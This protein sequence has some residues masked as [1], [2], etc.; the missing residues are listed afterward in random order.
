MNHLPQSPLAKIIHWALLSGTVATAPA[1]WAADAD[2]TDEESVERIE[3]TGSRIKRTDMETPS[4]V[5]SINREDIDRSGLT[6]LSDVLK[7]ITTN[8][9]SL[10]LQTNNGNT[11]GVS[12]I[13]LRN[14]GSNRTLVL[15]NGRR[16]VANLGG[17]VDIST[18]PLAAVARLEVL[19]D[20]ASSVYGTDAICG[21]VNVITRND[22]DGA[23][24]SAYRGITS[25]DDGERQSYALTI[26]SAGE[27]GSA[28]INASYTKQEG[29]LGGDRKISSTPID[30]LPA[31]ISA[32]GGRAS[33]VTP[34]GQFGVALDPSRPTV[35]TP[36]TLDPSAQ[37]CL[38][39]QRCTST[40][41]F[42]PYNSNSDGYNFAPVNYIN[43]PSETTSLFVQGGYDLRDNVRATT[44]ILFNERSSKAQLAAQ[45]LSGSAMRVSK[46]NV[47]NPFGAD[48]TGATFRPI[49]APREYSVD[50]DTW[51]F[52][53]GLEGDFELGSRSFS[54][55]VGSTYSDNELVQI[56]SG[57][58]NAAN[59]TMALGPSTIRDGR[60]VCT[61]ANA[62]SNCVPF[63]LFGGPTGVTPEM[64]NFVTVTPRNVDYQKMHDYSANLTGDLFDLPAGPLAM[65]VGMETRRESGYSKPD[66]LT[67]AG[68]VLGD[69]PAL[70]TEGGFDLKEAYVEFNVPVLNDLPGVD[71]LELSLATRHS[72]YS[73]FGTTDNPRFAL[74]Y[75]PFSDL[76]FRASKGE[77]FRA[78]SI[79]ELFQGQS[80]GR[81]AVTDPCS[82]NST[83]YLSNADVR[84]RCAAEGVS[85]SFVQLSPQAFST[86]GGNPDVQPEMAT[87][88]TMGFVYSPSFVE[89]LGVTL[90]WY[91]IKIENSIS[92]RG[93]QSI[94]DD[95]Y[96]SG[97]AGRCA[98]ITR[99]L[100]GVGTPNKGELS[101]IMDITSNFRGGQEV[102]GYDLNVDYRFETAVGTWRVNWDNAYTTYFGDV[103]QLHRGELNADGDLSD[104]NLVGLVTAGS[105]AGGTHF[106]LK[107]NITVA[108]SMDDWSASITAQYFSRQTERCNNITTA[109][110]GL[111]RPEL[112]A[113]CSNP[114]GK[115]IKYT[116]NNATGVIK[117]SEEAWPTN[118]L[119]AT[120]Y[121]DAQ[122]GWKTPWDSQVTVGIRNLTDEDPPH[123]YSAFA[124]T[125][126]P[127]YRVPGQFYY[128]SYTQN[129]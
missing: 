77:G 8:G 38:P 56:K 26:G 2:A 95:C 83:A 29:I 44:E 112:R 39:N 40:T 107:S 41:G 85:P 55:D 120:W 49:V 127:A 108:W 17:N 48:I 6:N 50:V 99:D 128:M 84:A 89:G 18:I 124:N 12:R 35:L 58:F 97:I 45:P 11:T 106:R 79:L 93:A 91:N 78:P 74:S 54:W 73:N 76:M 90:D 61:A 119:D 103:G 64:L 25:E 20:G 80:T 36:M 52:G 10:G 98:Q 33:P 75:R 70:P 30:G 126:D 32:S 9:A 86:G 51:R 63:N 37:G 47:Y 66:P 82:S 123:S 87:N 72:D 105:S 129:F 92:T 15:V 24:A 43:Q 46:D 109:A 23:Q 65:A 19:K 22:F 114:D 4:P 100:A 3:V 110:A 69:N 104:G 34:Y 60:A 31:N 96:L 16:W 102:E 115:H 57:F 42:R 67:S 81:P 53:L 71:S 117:T 94:L 13:D 21:V 101:G 1:A 62:P 14:C 113:L 7:E 68:Q 88:K 111:R 118:E 5:L 122:A 28:L 27:K 116:L 121:F 125:Y 59:M